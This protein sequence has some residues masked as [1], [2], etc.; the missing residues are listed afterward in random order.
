MKKESICDYRRKSG[1]GKERLLSLLSGPASPT[2]GKILLDGKDISGLDHDRY[3]SHD[4]GVIFQSFNLL[5]KLMAIEN[6]ILS[7]DISGKSTIIKRN[8]NGTT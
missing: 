7:M 3:R 6:V 4:I 5:P 2:K 8:S 1:R